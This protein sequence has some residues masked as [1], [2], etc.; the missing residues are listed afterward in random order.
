MKNNLTIF[1]KLRDVHTTPVSNN[2]IIWGY[3]RVS[4][5]DQLDNFSLENQKD[6]IIEYSQKNNFKVERFFG[7]TNESASK[8]LER[9]EFKKIFDS[10]KVAN[11]K[12]YAIAVFKM[13]RFSRTGSGAISLLYDVTKK[14]GVNI[15]ETSTGLCTANANDEI[16]MQYSLL[17]ARKENKNKLDASLPGMKKLLTKGDWLGKAPRGYTHYGPRVKDYSKIREKQEILVNK[18]GKLLKLAFKWKLNGLADVVIRTKLQNLGLIISKQSLSA[19]WRK[20]FYA[21][22]NNNK[23]LDNCTPGNWETMISKKDFLILQDLL[24][25]NNSNYRQTKKN[26]KFPLNGTIYCGKCEAKL[27]HY[28]IHNKNLDYYKCN[29]CQGMNINANNT[30]KSNSVGAH[31]LF[32]HKLKNYQLPEELSTLFIEELKKVFFNH[33]K[34]T[35]EERSI[36]KGKIT[37]QE[38]L[39]ETVE[40]NYVTNQINSELYHKYT[41][42]YKNKIIELN[43]NIEEIDFNLSNLDY[44]IKR[45]LELCSNIDILWDKA[46]FNLKQQ[47]Q[48]L[49]FPK[50]IKLAPN[51]IEYLTTHS[52]SL[53]KLIN[54][55]SEGKALNEKRLNN[56]EAEKSSLVDR[57]LLKSNQIHKDILEIV[58]FAENHYTRPPI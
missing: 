5:K 47:I 11:K 24:S 56:P 36:I 54:S 33:N 13:S 55:I 32:I 53:F 57:S 2:K 15:I 30:K 45:S 1:D 16:T 3:T 31:A 8:D 46:N 7:E 43:E 51:K 22:V 6:N 52:N 20:P 4:S 26:I 9:N 17:D 29:T 12:P 14:Y 34:T 35:Y 41:S 58:E 39:I 38:K 50:G 49:V 23:L 48:K 40:E 19:M 21:G 27:T 10:L 42:K 37:E 25:K 18:E 44:Y 28:T